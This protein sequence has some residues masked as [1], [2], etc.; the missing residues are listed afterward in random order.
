MLFLL[1]TY[2]YKC[3]KTL[4]ILVLWGLRPVLQLLPS[5]RPFAIAHAAGDTL[6]N[7]SGSL[8]SNTYIRWLFTFAF[9][10]AL[11]RLA[12]WLIKRATRKPLEAPE[13]AD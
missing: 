2:V 3:V 8:S 10:I 5:F 7:L 12:I 4:Q 13:K 6:I 9:R 11:C 1:L